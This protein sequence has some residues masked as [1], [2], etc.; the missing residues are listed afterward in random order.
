MYIHNTEKNKISQSAKIGEIKVLNKTITLIQIDQTVLRYFFIYDILVS[1][2]SLYTEGSYENR[3]PTS[4]P[5]SE[6]D[7]L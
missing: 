3:Q 6:Q 2:K 7:F 5:V 4:A 1:N